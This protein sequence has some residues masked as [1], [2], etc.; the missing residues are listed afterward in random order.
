MNTYPSSN[1][2]T[3]DPPPPPGVRLRLPTHPVRLTYVLIAINALVFVPT[4]LFGTLVYAVG[5][6]IPGLVLQRWQ[7]WRLL[8]AGFIHGDIMHIGF[9]M[10]ALY[11]FGRQV[12]R[13]FGS[14]RFALIYGTALLGGSVV[15]VLFN[16]QDSLTVGASGAILGL[17]GALMAYFWRYQETMLGARARL[18]NLITTAL[19]NLGLGLLPRVSL[20]GHLGGTLAGLAVGLMLVPHY[21]TVYGLQPHLDIMERQTEEWLGMLGVV[22]GCLVLLIMAFLLRG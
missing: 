22:A 10:Y 5:G 16:A 17:L 3:A 18:G 4:L 2:E 14:R 20:W 11:I 15:V 13:L 6:L 19:I 12:E 7:I 9:N 8:T 1:F 21:K